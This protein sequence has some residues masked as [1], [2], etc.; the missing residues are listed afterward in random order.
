MDSKKAQKIDQV[1]ASFCI[2]K[3]LQVTID[4]VHGTTHSCHHPKR[5]NIPLEEL[6]KNP[7]TLH[8]TQF[9]K[10][11]RRLMLEG[12][13]PEECEYCWNI[14][15]TPGS[16]YSDRYIKSLDPW[17]FPFLDKVK[18]LPW[19]QDI[20]PTYLE[21]MFDSACQLSCSY[22][23]A[24]ISSSIERE[25]KKY[26]PYPVMDKFHRDFDPEWKSFGRDNDNPYVKAFWKW[27]P[28][29]YQDLQYFR[30]TGGEPLLSPQFFKV[31]EFLKEN[32]SPKMTLAI[33]SNLCIQEDKW[34]SFLN[35]V[36]DIN[37]KIELYA[38]IDTWGEQ[39]EFIRY[40]LDFELFQKRCVEFCQEI[41]SGRLVLMVTFNLLSIPRFEQ[42]LGWV[43]EMKEKFPTIAFDISYLKEPSY[44]KANIL[45]DEL[46][47]RLQK[48]LEKFNNPLFSSH[49]K[50]KMQRIY[51]W[52]GQEVEREELQR[53]RSDFFGFINEYE[54]RY[55]LDFL[56]TFP[57]L[58]D[59]YIKCKK[60]K[61]EVS[62]MALTS[63]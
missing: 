57:E 9:K 63:K 34:A 49:E 46:R 1:S 37:Q 59:F 40:G 50:N 14:E 28:E 48:S 62:T 52:L 26:G 7:S 53:G 55:N 60:A 15:D 58:K 23:L 42:L 17:A 10:E 12:N 18:S 41:G 20:N 22:C 54:K 39:A 61:F 16:H 4:L 31:L 5:H 3:W 56:K 2:A 24:N 45:D 25:M 19:N 27:L 11:Q 8:N 32:P 35:Q 30:I 21:V 36:K 29:I 47:N 44:L 33:N 51:N 38:S 6:S 43:L 13:R